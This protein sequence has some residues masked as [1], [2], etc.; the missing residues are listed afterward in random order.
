MSLSLKG[1]CLN[2]YLSLNDL[3]VTVKVKA[4]LKV[5]VCVFKY[6]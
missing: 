6:N 2:E 1:H 4:I 3:H 5:C